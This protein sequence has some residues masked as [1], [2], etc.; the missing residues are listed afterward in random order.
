MEYFTVHGLFIPDIYEIKHLF[1]CKDTTVQSQHDVKEFTFENLAI[2]NNS[3]HLRIWENQKDHYLT[4]LLKDGLSLETSIPF[5]DMSEKDCNNCLK[6]KIYKIT[7]DLKLDSKAK[8]LTA[9]FVFDLLYPLRTRS[10]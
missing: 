5:K 4:E 2:A 9:F 7:D 8:Q 6:N 1:S 10:C 3:E